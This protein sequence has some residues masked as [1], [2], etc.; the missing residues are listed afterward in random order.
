MASVPTPAGA[1][2]ASVVAVP[3]GAPAVTQQATKERLVVTTDV[4][5][6]TFDTEGGT[7]V[8][9]SFN[10]FK[11]MADKDKGFVLLDESTGRVYVAQTGL[12]ASGLSLPTHKTLMTAVPGERSLKDG[13]NEL[14]IKLLDWSYQRGFKPTAGL[15]DAAYPSKKLLKDLMFGNWLWVSQVILLK[16]GSGTIR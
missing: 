13:V 14:A 12:I 6:L 9:S 2:T 16:M 8:R 15:F 10:K 4:F 3:I 11:D 1:N 7:L 5:A